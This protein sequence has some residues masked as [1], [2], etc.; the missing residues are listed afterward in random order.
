MSLTGISKALALSA[1]IL[2]AFGLKLEAEEIGKLSSYPLVNRLWIGLE[3]GTIRPAGYQQIRSRT[4][5]YIQLQLPDGAKVRDGE[6]WAIADPEQLTIEEESL[7]LE[8]E[9]LEQSLKKKSEDAEEAQIIVEIKLYEA[10]MKRQALVDTAESDSLP[11]SLKTRAAEAILKIDERIE[12]MRERADPSF[13]EKE[14]HIEE[15]GGRLGI[16]RTRKQFEALKKNSYLVADFDGEL[17]YSDELAEGAAERE[18]EADLIWMQAGEHLATIVNDDKFEIVVPAEGGALT[19]IQVDELLVYLQDPKTGRLI[20][21]DY[22]RTEELD[23]GA[24]IKRNYIFSIQEEAVPDARHSSGQR[25]LVHVYRKFETPVRLVQKKDIAFADPVTLSSGGWDGLVGSSAYLRYEIGFVFQQLN[26]L[27]LA[28]VERNVRLAVEMAGGDLAEN[29]CRRWLEYPV[30]PLSKIFIPMLLGFLA[31]G[32]L[33]LFAEVERELR[34]QLSDNSAYRVSVSEFVGKDRAPTILRRTY[35]EEML[36]TDTYGAEVI[37]QL[38]QPLVSAVWNRDQSVPLLAFTSSL[39]E[40]Q[41]MVEVGRPPGAW[42]LSNKTDHRNQTLE[43]SVGNR[44]TVAEVKPLPDWL[45]AGL[46]M[47]HAVVIPIEMIEPQLN[48]GFIN[49]MTAEFDDLEEV[50]HFVT[51]AAAYY[52]AE[53]RQVAGPQMESIGLQAT[54]LPAIPPEDMAIIVLSGF[55]GVIFAV[56]PVAFG[57]RKPPGLVL[58]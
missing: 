29:T 31:I 38:R 20:A 53:N 26:L 34:N 10:E 55:L 19:R 57:L 50:E 2:T 39:T 30:S 21:G 47:E 48:G 42:F 14:L 13:T 40:F 45:S 44:R 15:K 27:P 46:A 24:E 5:G 25:G 52:R 9:K 28:S 3:E 41:D 35:E 4:S 7:E 54:T 22:D 58:Q 37:R 18:S 12:V 16:A 1:F 56:I 23:T 6:V 17:R 32:V 43:I 49:H 51:N 8:E 33:T 36:W 11:E